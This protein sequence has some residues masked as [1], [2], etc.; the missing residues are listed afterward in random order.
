MWFLN[1]CDHPRFFV[2]V[3][4]DLSLGY[5]FG[6]VNFAGTAK[7]FDQLSQ[8]LRMK[9]FGYFYIL[10]DAPRAENEIELVARI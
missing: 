8:E 10:W 4:P 3:G 9:A 5:A 6:L 7:E 2:P 1:R